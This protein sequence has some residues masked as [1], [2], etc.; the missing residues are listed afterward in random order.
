MGSIHRVIHS[1]LQIQAFM[2][3][4]FLLFYAIFGRGERGKNARQKKASGVRQEATVSRD[5]ARETETK[6]F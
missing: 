3:L 2:T 1:K 5:D 4:N 6:L